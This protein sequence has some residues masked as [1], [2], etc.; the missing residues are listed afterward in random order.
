MEPKGQ[1]AVVTGGASGMGQ[2]CAEALSQCGVKVVVWDRHIEHVPFDAFLCDVTSES[3]VEE[4]LR[5]TIER[6]GLPRIC[7]NC[8]GVAPA[9]RM[10]NKD[11]V[12]P[13]HDFKRVIDI[14]LIGTFNVMSHVADAM[15]RLTPMPDSDERGVIVNTASIAAYEGQIGQM[16]YSAS[17]GGVV[18]MTLPAARELAQHGIR[19]NTIAPGLI[20]TPMLLSMPQ[21]IQDS[22]IATSLYPKRLGKPDEF[23]ALVK[24]II[25]NQFI[26]GEVIRLDGAVRL[27]P[28]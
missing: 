9:R 16:A 20:A 15:T 6:V 1:I 18:A 26:N 24:H 11:G 21:E 27:Q 28:R 4:A 7:V 14:N 10:V 5:N 12:M 17:K 23:A 8:A 25:E 2:A 13:L 19:V 22:L 3:A